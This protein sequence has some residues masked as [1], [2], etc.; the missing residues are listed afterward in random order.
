MFQLH[1]LKTEHFHHNVLLAIDLGPRSSGLARI[2]VGIDPIVQKLCALQH[3]LPKDKNLLLRDL[4]RLLSEEDANHL[5]IGIPLRENFALS[6]HALFLL[7]HIKYLQE[8][9]PC[10]IYL[11]DETL[12][13]KEARERAHISSASKKNNQKEN[14]QEIDML[15]AV[16]I[17]EDFLRND[18]FLT[19]DQLPVGV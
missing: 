14:K 6:E 7:E 15:S 13:T 4:A 18:S 12:T 1:P 5:V 17:L 10:T 8:N 9:L 3:Q 16:I 2:C 11:Q 19:I